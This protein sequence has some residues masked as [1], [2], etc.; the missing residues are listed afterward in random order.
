MDV[1]FLT[2]GLFAYSRH[3]NFAAEQTVWVT[4]YVWS[5][6]A[7][8]TWYNWTGVGAVGYLILF[9]ASTWL[10]E[11]LSAKKYP[12]YKAYQK[13]VGKFLPLPGYTHP[14]FHGHHAHSI[15]PAAKEKDAAQ[16]RE[17]YELR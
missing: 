4:L 15:D 17:R 6:L 1:G 10:T 9:Q 5:C 11:L 13:Q 3:P 12:E 16:A 2:K 7:T 8:D 14:K